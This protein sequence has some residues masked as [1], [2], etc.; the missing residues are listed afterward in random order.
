MEKIL[1]YL[2]MIATAVVLWS[3]SDD[4][5]GEPKVFK[6]PDPASYTN[7]DKWLF[8]NYTYP[9]NIMFKY[10]MQDIESDFS[11]QLTP[12]TIPKAIIMAKLVKHLWIEVYDELV[13]MEFTR[14]HI[15]KV[16]HL[17]GSR[18]ENSNGSAVIGMAHS[19]MKVTLYNINSLDPSNI[20]ADMMTDTYLKTLHHEFAHI[21]HQKIDYPAEFRK[22]TNGDYIEDDWSG[23]DAT[24][25]I[26]NQKGFVSRYARKAYNEDFVEIFSIYVTRGQANW[27]AILA[28]S[29]TIAPGN[30]RTGKALIEEKLEI[31]REYMFN[32][33]NIDLDE[34]RR[35][36]EERLITM[37]DL[38]LINL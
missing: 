5:L 24:L 3:C 15:P 26:A 12:T 1:K 28:A 10:K 14:T 23:T 29:N 8:S 7:F 21:L 2:L 35:V 11:Y 25:P 6:D 31:V 22:V 32:V 19:G 4:K 13:G 18:A 27:D 36:L 17:I 33:W 9:Y 38:D 34:T 30:T 20:T 16:I 37:H